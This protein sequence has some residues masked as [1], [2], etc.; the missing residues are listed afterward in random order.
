MRKRLVM[1]VF[2]VAALAAAV[3]ASAELGLGADVVSRYVWRGTDFGDAVSVQPY[4]SYATGPVEIGTW[5]SYPV[6][7]VGGANEHDLY[8]TYSVQDLSITL[9]DYYF[10]QGGNLLEFGKDDGAHLLEISASY[11][12]GSISLM[13]AFNFW[14]DADDSY[15]AEV[16]Y[17]LPELSD[18]IEAGVF[19]GLG[20]G[21]YTTDSDPAVVN[22]GLSV[23]SDEYSASYIVNPEAETSF[24]VFGLSF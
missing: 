2:A 3:P 5:A 4:I 21:V 20:N 7:S 14:N 13:G 12:V 22:I 24:L 23:S 15:Y 17:A 18:G 8:V 1:T 19:A 10:P 11:A 6:T 16:G 9:T